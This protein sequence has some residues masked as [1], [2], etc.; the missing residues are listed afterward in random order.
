MERKLTAL[1]AADVV[2]YSR[3]MEQDEA[4]TLP[5]CGTAASEFST[6]CSHST[7]A[8]SS[9]SW[10]TVCWLNLPAL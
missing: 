7:K 3:L 6:P 9:K 5:H 10:V 4:S 8:A 1:L 2:G